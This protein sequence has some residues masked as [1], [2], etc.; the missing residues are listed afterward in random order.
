LTYT[1]SEH[2]FGKSFVNGLTVYA[3]GANL[4]TFSKNREILDLSIGTTPQFKYYN[5][6][7]RAKF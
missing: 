4:Y 5:A 1:F 7:I 2:V 6:G 3:S